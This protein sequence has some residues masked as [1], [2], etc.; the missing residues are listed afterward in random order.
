M[1]KYKTSWLKIK[2]RTV[3]IRKK[4]RTNKEIKE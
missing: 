3:M 4:V 2:E 1:N